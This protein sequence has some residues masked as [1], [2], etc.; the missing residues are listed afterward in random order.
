MNSDHFE[1]RLQHQPLRQIPT[2]WRAEILSKAHHA[3]RITHHALVAPKS[4]EGGSRLLLARHNL[5]PQLSTLN[6][7]VAF[8]QGMGES[9]SNLAPAA[10]RECFD[11]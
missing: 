7:P 4:D 8:P 2:E 10:H 3:S 5:N 11:Q 9:R 6:S 1:Q